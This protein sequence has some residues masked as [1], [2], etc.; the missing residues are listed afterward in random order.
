MNNAHLMNH[1]NLVVVHFNPYA[2]GKFFINC[3]SHNPGVLPG[4][5]VASPI[6]TYD[7]WLFEDVNN[8]ESR[9]IERINST[10]PPLEDMLIWPSYEL[11]CNGFW[12]AGFREIF[13][14]GCTPGDEAI[15]LLDNN[16]CFIVN[17]QVA[18]TIVE[19]CINSCPD[20]RHIIL[21]NHNRFQ[22]RAAEIKAPDC[23]LSQMNTVPFNSDFFYVDVDNTY[24][25]LGTIKNTVNKCLEWLEVDNNLHT[26]IDRYITQYLELHR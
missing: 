6:H 11:G 10:I 3:L 17:H 8:V 9:K 22:K 19:K 20:A 16:I 5:C 23:H 14:D 21:Y 13:F 2:G 18:D 26:N 25:D 4:L 1:R 15:N 7:N 24:T 12:G